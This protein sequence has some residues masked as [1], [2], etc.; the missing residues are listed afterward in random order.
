[1]AIIG[2]INLYGICYGG[3]KYVAVGFSSSSGVNVAYSTD[4][5]N[6]ETARIETFSKFNDVI[7]VNGKFIAAGGN[8][9]I[10]SSTDGANWTFITLEN[11]GHIFNIVYENGRYVAVSGA[12]YIA[13]SN[14]G[15]NWVTKEIENISEFNWV[16]YGNGKFLAVG[17]LYNNGIFLK[18]TSSADGVNWTPV[19]TI[20]GSTEFNSVTY[21]D[22]KYVGVGNNGIVT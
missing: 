20:S 15:V 14:D 11:I 13:Y 12:G 19:E 4:G 18:V 21:G 17:Y 2:N 10:A 22:G 5:I 16:T 8:G 1:M 3:G 7:Y 9:E 6:W